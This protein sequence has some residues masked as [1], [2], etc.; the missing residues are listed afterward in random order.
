MRVLYPGEDQA[1]A[2]PVPLELQQVFG[3]AVQTGKAAVVAVGSLVRVLARQVQRRH[4]LA[5][6]ARVFE[7]A[8]VG[9]QVNRRVFVLYITRPR[10][11]SSYSISAGTVPM[12]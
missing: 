7:D 9:E 1:P 10:G 6:D 5:D 11:A 2:V 8:A 4:Y 3:S 12:R